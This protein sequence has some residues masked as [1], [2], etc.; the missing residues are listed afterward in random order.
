MG[1]YQMLCEAY[2]I[3]KLYAQIHDKIPWQDWQ[4]KYEKGVACSLPTRVHSQELSTEC[5]LFSVNNN[6]MKLT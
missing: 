2:E 1:L 5:S 4:Q 6:E 3:V